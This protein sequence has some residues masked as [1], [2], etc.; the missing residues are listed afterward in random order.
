M[1]GGRSWASYCKPVCEGLH[2]IPARFASMVCV[3]C[4]ASR[5]AAAAVLGMSPPRG[6]AVEGGRVTTR[7]SRRFCH[8]GRIPSRVTKHGHMV[9]Y[10]TKHG[11]MGRYRGGLWHQLPAAPSCWIRR[12]YGLRPERGGRR[13]LVVDATERGA[14]VRRASS[15]KCL[16]RKVSVSAFCLSAHSNDAFGLSAPTRHSFSLTHVFA[17]A[18]RLSRCTPLLSAHHLTAR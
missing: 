3:L 9:R 15:A 13:D 6:L 7:V 16:C 4:V 17:R 1:R 18:H 11:H 14:A 5:C 10:V 8:R 12:R 2:E